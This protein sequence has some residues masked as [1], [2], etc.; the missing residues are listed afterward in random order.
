MGKNSPFFYV[1]KIRILND[2][3]N[4][5]TFLRKILRCLFGDE[6]SA[7]EI[8]MKNCLNHLLPIAY[9]RF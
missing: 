3:N 7:C 8:T 9:R 1:R 5:K 6:K 2:N 4:E